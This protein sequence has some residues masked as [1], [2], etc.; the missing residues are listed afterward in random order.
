MRIIF[1]ISKNLNLNQYI[2]DYKVKINE[3]LTPLAYDIFKY[4][5]K[6]LSPRNFVHD[7]AEANFALA[8]LIVE[9]YER[10]SVQT[11]YARARV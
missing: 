6:I 9:F 10:C 5:G 8:L 4:N 11:K 7:F 1:I 2:H 3:K